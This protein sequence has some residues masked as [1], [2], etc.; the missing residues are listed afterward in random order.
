MEK[1]KRHWTGA[2]AIEEGVAETAKDGVLVRTPNNYNILL[3]DGPSS[4]H[5]HC[6]HGNSFLLRLDHQFGNRYCPAH[7]G[8]TGADME[9]TVDGTFQQDFLPLASNFF[10]IML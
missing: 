9:D 1:S 4:G 7:L 10:S 8:V 6:G 3:S 2:C 5:R